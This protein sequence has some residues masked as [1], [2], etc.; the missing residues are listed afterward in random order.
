MSGIN[1]SDTTPAALAGGLNVKW[2]SDANGNISAYISNAVTSVFGRTGA[3]VAASGDYTAAQVT[4]AVS[5]L[6]SYADPAWITSLAA[7]KLTGSPPAA[8]IAAA[9]TPWLQDVNA[10]G[11]R[12]LNAGNV[13]IG[14]TTP[15]TTLHIVSSLQPSVILK[16]ASAQSNVLEFQD[17]AVTPN[18]WWIGQGLTSPTDGTFL[19][20]DARQ[21]VGRVCVTASGNVGIG[22]TSPPAATLEINGSVL[23]GSTGGAFLGN[24]Y[25]NGSNW[26]YR[27]AGAGFALYADSGQINFFGASAGSAGTTAS[28]LQLFKAL[29]GMTIFMAPIGVS[30]PAPGN[31][32]YEGALPNGSCL[33]TLTSNTSLTFRV[34]GSDGVIRQGSIT[35]A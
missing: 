31:G 24:L 35:L 25:F 13:G 32:A 11:F 20:Y 16:T 4:N 27:T 5:S 21:S 28:P 17:S 30:L 26:V 6:G 14:T 2:Q 15:T 22:T 34:K 10:A 33:F 23:C 9:Q 19:I 12:L 7:A 18:R 3:V 29:S 8:V 1:F